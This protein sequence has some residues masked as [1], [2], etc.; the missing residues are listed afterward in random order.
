M[1]KLIL[2]TT[3]G[4]YLPDWKGEDWIKKKLEAMDQKSR[5]ARIFF[6]EMEETEKKYKD[7]F[8]R[9][10]KKNE[11]KITQQ[12]DD[13]TRYFYLSHFEAALFQI[14]SILDISAHI[15]DKVFNI[16]T[17]DKR[18]ITFGGVRKYYRDT[19]KPIPD[20]E[21]GKI[22]NKMEILDD[23][24]DN[25]RNYIAHHFNLPASLEGEVGESLETK[26]DF[27]VPK[28]I[29]RKPEG[30]DCEVSKEKELATARME[31]WLQQI[32]EIIRDL[33]K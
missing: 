25:Y 15:F 1:G 8:M 33:E 4:A 14:N 12:K 2:K 31:K 16:N 20:S 32:E 30:G 23:E 9:V 6:R 11:E 21:D 3:T 13:Y 22:F 27:V 26:W 18:R 24:I 5:Y 19:K 17:P 10:N 28:K 29:T 7:Y